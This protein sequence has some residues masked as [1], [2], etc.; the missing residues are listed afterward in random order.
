MRAIWPGALLVVYLSATAIVLVAGRSRVSAAGIAMHVAVLAAVAAATWVPRLPQWLMAWAPL[1]SLFFLYTEMPMLIRAAGHDA[2]YDALVIAWENSLFGGQ[3]SL[4]WAARWPSRVL[5]ELLHLAYLGYYAI[6]VSV[7]AIL[8][9]L[10]RRADFSEAVFVLMLTFVICFLFYLIFPVAGP[11]YLATSSADAPQGPIRSLV[12]WLLET[13]SSRGTAFPSSHVAVA[14][15]QSILAIRYFGARGLPVGA[16]SVGLALGAIYGGF[17]Y[18]IDVIA[19][20][21]VGLLTGALGLGLASWSNR[22]R[23]SQ[24]KATAPT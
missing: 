5:S 9:R 24:A 12:V 2:V 3:P 6:I 17:H 1:L 15:A 4:E 20:I 10:S 8:Y 14:V 19:G 11:R 13:R 18:A 7:P 23:A 21:L 16:V 22:A